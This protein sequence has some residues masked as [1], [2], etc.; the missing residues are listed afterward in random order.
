MSDFIKEYS[1]QW[2]NNP[3]SLLEEYDYHPELTGELDELDVEQFN[4][5]TLYKIVLWKLSRF[6][7]ITDELVNELKGI[8]DIQPKEHQ[9][10]R[11]IL[12]KFLRTPGIA[13]PMASTI[14]RFINPNAFQIIDDRAY[15]VLLPGKAKYPSKP[16]KITDS[17]INKSAEIY[18][19]YLDRMHEIC[20]EKLPF[21]KADRILYQLDVKLGNKIGEKT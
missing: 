8:K 18:F 12:G 10:A 2:G 7:Y 5:E 11:D 9:N 6:P 21:D 16:Q 14:L 20:S 1:D 4:Y 15:R 13:L 19:N 17:Y 3:A